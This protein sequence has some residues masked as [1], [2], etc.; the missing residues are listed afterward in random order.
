[1]EESLMDKASARSDTLE[2]QAE[3]V[4]PF[5]LEEDPEITVV[6]SQYSADG[7]VEKTCFRRFR[8]RIIGTVLLCFVIGVGVYLYSTRGELAPYQD[9]QRYT[10]ARFNGSTA[11]YLGNGCFWERQY[12]YSNIETRC[13]YQPRPTRAKCTPFHRTD[14][15]IT[16]V[17]GYAGS[18]L[19]HLPCYHHSGDSSDGTLYETLGHAEAVSVELEA[20]KEEVQFSALLVDYFDSFNPTPQGMARPDPGDKGP[21]YRSLLGI[22][23]GVHGP[24]YPLVEQHNIH[25]MELVEGRGKG[26]G[27]VFNRVWIMDSDIFPFHRG[28]QYHQFHSNFFGP[29]YPDSYVKDLWKLHISLGTIP[30]TGCPEGRHW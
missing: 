22:P 28:E 3:E 14:A 10:D 23:G 25:S 11:V 16:A 17:V 27:D 26:D 21:P 7:T 4:L 1:M 6:T 9:P 5:E 8:G 18:A 13:D 29:Q 12:A 20:G 19:P 15:Q 24:L 30:P 2:R